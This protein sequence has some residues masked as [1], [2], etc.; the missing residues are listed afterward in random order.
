MLVDESTSPML[1][2]LCLDHLVGHLI[3][4]KVAA[5]LPAEQAL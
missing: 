5:Q 2:A 4:M 3:V 1:R